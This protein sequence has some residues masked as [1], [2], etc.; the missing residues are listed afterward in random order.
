MELNEV[1]HHIYNKTILEG[2]LPSLWKT[3]T[4]IPVPKKAKATV[5]NDYRPVA[6]TPVVMKCLE[7]I[8][9]K[10][11][12]PVVSPSMD[13]L[14]FAYRKDRGV[15]DATATMLNYVYQHLDMQ[16][17]YA[18]ALFIDFSSAFNTI[19]PRVLVDKLQ[20]L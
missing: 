14:Q 17:T 15:E 18:R 3:A 2:T 19:M 7:R 4:I 16:G 11:L 13:T 9:L 10:R 1:F 12:L 5:L 6:L 20:S 8:I